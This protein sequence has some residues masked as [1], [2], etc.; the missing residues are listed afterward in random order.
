MIGL[1]VPLLTT[2]WVYFLLLIVLLRLANR[3]LYLDIE[4]SAAQDSVLSLSARERLMI[5]MLLLTFAIMHWQY[6]GWPLISNL[7]E[8]FLAHYELLQLLSFTSE[9]DK[10]YL[11][12]LVSA[13]VSVFFI[14]IVMV[15]IPVHRESYVQTVQRFSILAL[16]LF[17]ALTVWDYFIPMMSS[18]WG[19]MTRWP[20]IGT[21][22]STFMQGTFGV[23]EVTA[24]LPS[25]L[26]SLA[27][28]YFL[29]LIVRDISGRATDAILA[30][31]FC[32]AAPVFFLYSHLDFREIGGVFFIT[33]GVYY[34]LRYLRTEQLVDLVYVMI[35]ISAGYL[36]RRTAAILIFIVL[37]AILV[38]III[39]GLK[40]RKFGALFHKIRTILLLLV[41]TALIIMPWVFISQSVR[42]Y[43]FHAGNFLIWKHLLAYPVLLPDVVGW[44]FLFFSVAGIVISIKTKSQAG[45]VAILWLVIAYILFTGDYP[46][47]IPVPRFTVVIVPALGILAGLT[48]SRIRLKKFKYPVY[49][50]LTLLAV[51]PLYAWK[52]DRPLTAIY[53]V[54]A[55]TLSDVSYYPFNELVRSLNDRKL[56]NKVLLYPAY[57]QTPA[58]YYFKLYGMEDYSEINPS[59]QSK[60]VSV[61]ELHEAC[62]A[63]RCG[64]V[65][66]AFKASDKRSNVL[67][68]TDIS[69]QNVLE[70]QIPGFD[71]VALY[72]HKK[73]WLAL[74]VPETMT[75]N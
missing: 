15:R 61:N 21:L 16:I 39:P 29:Y 72:S 70:N 48:F 27:T 3:Q 50:L 65:V 42:P 62:I 67:F 58:K 10:K 75:D 33:A 7:D 4:M 17:I 49:L 18:R 44:P 30:V 5:G 13:A 73:N 56:T 34:L 51:M 8:P 31:V 1:Q 59:R 40:G 54:S 6:L 69:R 11:F 53:P 2:A 14:S 71:V 25:L 23:S 52:H 63:S 46:S 35:F 32:L 47:W 64:A 28:G 12:F 74:I 68:L 57:W 60:P 55:I 45:A 24:R 37:A 41:I 26:F 19:T 43:I 38:F 9:A 20:P 22:I 66:L 36:Q